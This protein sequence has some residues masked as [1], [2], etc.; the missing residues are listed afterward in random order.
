MCVKYAFGVLSRQIMRFTQNR[1]AK[2]NPKGHQ[3]QRHFAL[4]AM[5]LNLADILKFT[6]QFLEDVNSM[7]HVRPERLPKLVRAWKCLDIAN[8][9]Q[10]E[11]PIMQGQESK[12]ECESDKKS[13]IKAQH[14]QTGLDDS[15]EYQGPPSQQEHEQKVEKKPFSTTVQSARLSSNDV[16]P[17]ANP[18]TIQSDP[19]ADQREN[20]TG[21]SLHNKH[22]GSIYQQEHKQKIEQR[23][24]TGIRLSD[25]QGFTTQRTSQALKTMLD[26]KTDPFPDATEYPADLGFADSLQSSS[27]TEAMREKYGKHYDPYI[28]AVRYDQCADESKEA[29]EEPSNMPLTSTDYD[30]CVD[31]NDEAPGEPSNMPLT[32]TDYE[33][34]ADESDEAPEEPSNVPR[35]SKDYDSCS[36]ES[37][38]APGE[39]SNMPLTSTDYDGCADESDEAPEEPSSMARESTKYAN[40]RN[41][42]FDTAEFPPEFDEVLRQDIISSKWNMTIPAEMVRTG[43]TTWQVIVDR[44]HRHRTPGPDEGEGG[45]CPQQGDADSGQPRPASE[46]SFPVSDN[47]DEDGESQDSSSW[48]DSE[49]GD[50]TDS[51]HWPWKDDAMIPG[52]PGWIKNH[53]S[54]GA[55]DSFQRLYRSFGSQSDANPDLSGLG[56]DHAGVSQGEPSRAKTEQPGEKHDDYADTEGST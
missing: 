3:G 6:A 27:F 15:N 28:H 51:D 4:A 47:G 42:G 14:H 26:A 32:S 38:E 52:G 44:M 17:L 18:L 25:L 31:E 16:E 56:P 19:N 7:E 40:A 29:P 33:G 11:D 21:L 10:L 22:Q 5:G 12:G 9:V 49:N 39:L 1:V 30:P 53:F 35:N 43:Y 36:D 46:A 34:C 20:H 55:L 54:G 8:N 24:S 2:T 37:D 45:K 48:E 23:P 50:S 13:T 41:Y